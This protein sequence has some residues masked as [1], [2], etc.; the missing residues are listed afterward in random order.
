VEHQVELPPPEQEGADTTPTT[1]RGAAREGRPARSTAQEPARRGGDRRELSTGGAGALVQEVGSLQEVLVRMLDG[2]V[3]DDESLSQARELLHTLIDKAL[4]GASGR[5][6]SSVPPVSV[7]DEGREAHLGGTG[8]TSAPGPGEDGAS[9]EAE[10]GDEPVEDQ[11]EPTVDGR[12]PA[13]APAADQLL[14]SAPAAEEEMAAARWLRA[15]GH[16]WLGRLATLR[17]GWRWTRPRVVGTMAVAAVLVG[18]AVW[19]G[20]RIVSGLPAGVAFEVDGTTI[21]TTA[22]NQQLSTLEALYGIQPPAGAAAMSKFERSVAQALVTQVVIEHAGQRMGVHVTTQDARTLLAQDVKAQYGSQGGMSAFIQELGQRGITEAEVLHALEVQLTT[23]KVFDRV[24]GTVRVT[25]QELRA[26]YQSDKAKLAVP[27]TRAV[28]HIVVATKTEAESVMRKL[29]SGASFAAMAKA[30]SLDAST[31]ASGGYLGVL[32]QSEL[33]KPF[34]TAAFE[35]KPGVPFGPVKDQYGW[36]IGLVTKV[37]PGHPTSFTAAE[38][39]LRDY[40]VVKTEQDRWDAWLHRQL[41][42]AGARYASAYR[43]LHPTRPPTPV[44]PPLGPPTQV[45]QL[46]PVSRVL[47]STGGSMSIGGS[48]PS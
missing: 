6:G 12:E 14:G 35:A 1:E 37:V 36:E 24:V 31:A 42:L 20:F 15:A 45:G 41:V 5:A 27:E 47:P 8:E 32:S 16:R 4:A 19:L 34:G 13:K 10:A 29:E 18:L 17:A 3:G 33:D 22:F 39:E 7:G 11:E 25:D 30:Y 9:G 21:S 46:A 40:L 23:E 43:P 48:G 28:S 2:G 44:L 38:T 26:L